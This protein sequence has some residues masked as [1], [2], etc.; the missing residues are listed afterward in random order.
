MILLRSWRTPRLLHLHPL[1]C[2]LLLPEPLR[3]AFFGLDN[4]SVASLALVH[5]LR[6]KKPELIDL[7]DVVTRL[8]KPTGR[9]MKNYMELPVGQYA[10]EHGI[11]ILRA[12]SGA[13]I[14]Q[15]A[16]RYNMVVAVLYGKLIPG[17]FIGSCG[18][19]GLNVHP[20][21][22]PKYSGSSPIQ[23]ALMND[24]KETGVTVQS[25]HPTKFDHGE[26]IAQSEPVG[27]D[28]NDTFATLAPKLAQIGG[29]LLAKV[30]AEHAFV[31]P[32]GVTP[33]T[34]FSL[35]GKIK[36]TRYQCNWTKLARQIKRQADALGLLHTFKQVNIVRKKKPVTGPHKV[37]LNGIHE[38]KGDSQLAP[39][40]FKLDGDQ[41]VIG[42]GEGAVTVDRL[43][44]QCCNEETPKKFMSQLEK[45]TGGGQVFE[46]IK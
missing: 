1:R 23:Y 41:L 29:G 37:N 40:E 3:I 45:R 33:V 32:K 25:L 43:T 42:C 7:I 22:L 44:F 46:Y 18:Y 28:P 27:I 34:E 14:D 21:L 11:P 6:Q 9:G 35:A 12:D 31:N 19:G 2:Y 20:S 30:L 17:T 10:Q 13:D 38:Y 8:I 24:D 36:P 4:F 16:G 39:G 15:L 5:A 26:I